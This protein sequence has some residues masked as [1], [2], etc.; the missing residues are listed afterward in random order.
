ME[1]LST[2]FESSFSQRALPLNH[3]PAFLIKP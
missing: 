1:K 2:A 3:S